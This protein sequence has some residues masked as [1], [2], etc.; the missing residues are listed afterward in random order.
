VAIAIISMFAALLLPAVQ[1][2][3][4]AARRTQCLN[5]LKQLALAA[6][7]FHE[8]HR[9][10]PA[11]GHVPVPVGDRPT[12][13]TNLFVELLPHIDQANLFEKWDRYDNR[14]NA[15]GGRDATQ[16]Q[17]IPILLCPSD[18]LPEN[19]VEL[20]AANTPAWSHGFYGMSSYGGNAGTRTIGL[21]GLPGSRDGIFFID[22]CVR[23]ADII[24]GTSSTLL[25]GERYHLDPE[26]EDRKAVLQP[27]I[28]SLAHLGKWGMLTGPQG[29][30][31]NMTLHTAA[32]INYRMPA[33]GNSSELNGRGGAFGS[34]HTGGANVAFA[35]GSVHFLN[36]SISLLV[37]QRLGTRRGGEVVSARDF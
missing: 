35:D 30:M 18:W 25:F 11:G 20:T 16:A 37:L 36:A 8:A 13:G 12:G 7:N 3:R 22:S 17:V 2:A 31:G 34:G 23:I 21:G 1:Q 9:Q 10:F 19:V 29:I 24:D 26:W 28:D 5:N 14:N 33:G 6:Q 4:E 27:G 32:P 15:A